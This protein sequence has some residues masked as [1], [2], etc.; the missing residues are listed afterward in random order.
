MHNSKNLYK[1]I[2][3]TNYY[4]I[5]SW[6]QAESKRNNIYIIFVGNQSVHQ[7][8]QVTF[9]NCYQNDSLGLSLYCP[10]RA[11]RTPL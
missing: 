2:K 8:E 3:L 10:P 1:K 6:F 5:Q 11:A 7:G 9:Q 4:P